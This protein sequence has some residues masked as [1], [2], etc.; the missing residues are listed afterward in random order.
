MGLSGL[1]L[2]CSGKKW[3][4]VGSNGIVNNIVSLG[5]LSHLLYRE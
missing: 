3:K 5:F 2:F 1:Y 4:K